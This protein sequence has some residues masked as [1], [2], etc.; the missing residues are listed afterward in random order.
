MCPSTSVSPDPGSSGH[1]VC[2]G[3]WLLTGLAPV[4][5]LLLLW[6]PISGSPSGTGLCSWV[7]CTDSLP[8][9]DA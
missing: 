3:R 7:S 6:A 8:A 4:R 5:W 2:G 1:R 9:A